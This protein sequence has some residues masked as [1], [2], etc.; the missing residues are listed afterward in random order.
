[1]IRFLGILSVILFWIA[2]IAVSPLI[3]FL[4]VVLFLFSIFLAI[5]S[6]VYDVTTNYLKRKTR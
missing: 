5:S 3:I 1:M 6:I 2:A 4:G